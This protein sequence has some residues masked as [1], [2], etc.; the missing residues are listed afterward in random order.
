MGPE[1]NSEL[2]TY[3]FAATNDQNRKIILESL[4]GTSSSSQVAQ[5]DFDPLNREDVLRLFR[6]NNE[7]KYEL[8]FPAAKDPN[9]RG[10]TEEEAV[11]VLT[12]ENGFLYYKAGD[13]SSPNV[14]WQG[15]WVPFKGDAP[16]FADGNDP[17]FRMSKEALQ[18]QKK[19]KALDVQLLWEKRAEKAAGFVYGSKLDHTG[20]DAYKTFDEIWVSN[21]KSHGGVDY[22]IVDRSDLSEDDV[23]AMTM[24]NLAN[25]EYTE[26]VIGGYRD[27]VTDKN[28]IMV[29]QL[30][31][32]LDT[33]L[34]RHNTNRSPTFVDPLAKARQQTHLDLTEHTQRAEDPQGRY[35]R[36]GKAL[37]NGLPALMATMSIPFTLSAEVIS[38][39]SQAR[40]VQSLIERHPELLNVARAEAD[41]SGTRELFEKN[42]RNCRTLSRLY[43]YGKQA[44]EDELRLSKHQAGLLY[45]S[46]GKKI[47]LSKVE[48]EKLR[49]EADT[50]NA[51]QSMMKT[52]TEQVNNSILDLIQGEAMDQQMFVTTGKSK[53][54]KETIPQESRAVFKEIP[55]V[56][57]FLAYQNQE[58]AP[59]LKL[60][61]EHE[62]GMKAFEEVLR[63]TGLTKDSRENNA[64]LTKAL[65]GHGL[66]PPDNVSDPKF[67]Y[68]RAIREFAVRQADRKAYGLAF[69]SEEGRKR[70]LTQLY[71]KEDTATASG[72]R[73][74]DPTSREDLLRLYRRNEDGKYAPAFPE[75]A[76][77]KFKPLT[78]EQILDVFDPKKGYLYFSA[79]F[80]DPRSA[81]VFTEN[82]T[83]L[84]WSKSDWNTGKSK[85]AG[86]EFVG[87]INPRKNLTPKELDAELERKSLDKL[88][89]EQKRGVEVYRFLYGSR[90]DHVGS[91]TYRTYDEIWV[92]KIRERGGEEYP[93]P[94][95]RALPEDDVVALT[96]LNLADPEVTGR[97]FDGVMD[98]M[99][100]PRL[101][102]F[103]N[104][105]MILDTY[106]NR[107][108]SN[109]D[110]V[111]LDPIVKSRAATKSTL[112]EFYGAEENAPGRYDRM[113]D[114]LVRALPM[115]MSLTAFETNINGTVIAR[116]GSLQMVQ[117]L[118]ERHP[119]LL[120]TA[121]EKAKA[122]DGKEPGTL[123]KFE[124][125]LRQCR[126]QSKMY[127]FG[128]TLA[129]NKL[130]YARYQAG[131]LLDNEGKKVSLSPDGEKKLRLEAAKRGL[132]E[133]M[134]QDTNFQV[135]Q[136]GV[137]PVM[138][139]IA[140]E[141][142]AF[143]KTGRSTFLNDNIELR[144]F[145]P[146]RR[147]KFSELFGETGFYYLKSQEKE[148]PAMLTLL[149][150]EK[151]GMAVFDDILAK[152]KDPTD[153]REI[154]KALIDN[155]LIPADDMGDLS[156]DYGTAIEAYNVRNLGLK[157]EYQT[158]V[159][160]VRGTGTS[161]LDRAYQR[162]HDHGSFYGGLIVSDAI[163]EE[164]QSQPASEFLHFE[165]G[166]NP[167]EHYVTH[168]IPEMG[169]HR[170]APGE[171]GHG[172][173]YKLREYMNKATRF[174]FK[175]NFESNGDL[176]NRFT[177]MDSFLDTK[178]SDIAK[179]CRIPEK[180]TDNFLAFLKDHRSSIQGLVIGI[181]TQ[182][183]KVA[184]YEALNGHL[185]QITDKKEAET[186]RNFLQDNLA[187]YKAVKQKIADVILRPED[188]DTFLNFCSCEQTT[189]I[190]RNMV[191][192]VNRYRADGGLVP[193]DMTDV[194]VEFPKETD[195]KTVNAFSFHTM[196]AMEVT[197]GG[198]KCALTMESSAPPFGKLLY[199]PDKNPQALGLY[200]SVE[201]IRA[202][203][204]VPEN[205]SKQLASA[206]EKTL[207]DQLSGTGYKRTELGLDKK[208]YN[209]VNFSRD[210]VS[211]PG[212]T[213]EPQQKDLS[214]PVD[215]QI[216]QLQGFSNRIAASQ[217]QIR[218]F[219][220]KQFTDLQRKLDDCL[221]FMKQQRAS[222]PIYIGAS[223]KETAQRLSEL[224][225]Y[226]RS[227][228]AI[229]Q[230]DDGQ[231]K[232]LNAN[233]Q[234]RYD[235]ASDLKTYAEQ[236]EPKKGLVS[237]TP[238]NL[239]S[240]KDMLEKFCWQIVSAERSLKGKPALEQDKFDDLSIAI[241]AFQKLEAMNSKEKLSSE[242]RA[243]AANRVYIR[244]QRFIDAERIAAEKAGNGLSPNSSTRID[245]A[246][247][248]Q[249]FATEYG[250]LLSQE[251]D[252]AKER[253]VSNKLKNPVKAPVAM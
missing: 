245:L 187:D 83:R 183:Q 36:M 101:T 63:E 92:S 75:A 94:E 116:R 104:I 171:G 232:R 24:L 237:A 218:G 139:T 214:N 169:R 50:R 99:K 161:P 243:Q 205:Y 118:L 126:L 165:A 209:F 119:Q 32:N 130:R 45:D 25:P 51:L 136:E 79:G 241:L 238:K 160:G 221:T 120:E 227:Y 97:E 149:L 102:T 6:R 166:K 87:D 144:N 223:E 7:G 186:V 55:L 58:V 4:L 64:A 192:S 84:V 253:A 153:Y 172:V 96:L 44:M 188:S 37:A 86:P 43:G 151:G 197:L 106:E 198:K 248:L 159:D 70:V 122:L 167:G 72:S 249:G 154:H 27:M 21:V 181:N 226:V 14:F 199:Q 128:K 156:F 234:T 52:Y 3:G 168:K 134:L 252:K 158:F 76:G 13:N 39:C 174:A 212:K 230:D 98:P 18:E 215:R 201:E 29:Y 49:V 108:S 110:P 180:E 115:L 137:A 146:D 20:S 19:R 124:K 23:I 194:K 34:N 129:E 59:V 242:I 111:F 148:M 164:L 235:I 140:A 33:Y 143:A 78:E 8:A 195:P 26:N 109:T 56:G 135:M 175:L 89:K 9:F 81:Y 163:K 225:K 170:P 127:D 250:K 150:E 202:A 196:S 100:D 11:S 117:N 112:T 61:L 93:V 177:A 247:N 236:F 157:P 141:Q 233:G 48:A 91:D 240:G 213:V 105:E 216:E 229:K 113:A 74:F 219:S 182:L 22:P 2:E 107:K 217:K 16:V 103:K 173:S 5:R 193:I 12:P 15:G 189:G 46:E 77:D 184:Y 95:G 42:L 228:L 67:D 73:F 222:D 1:Q 132:V 54:L 152:A 203:Y 125:S 155:K 30:D 133:R 142:K 68:D 200:R 121:R 178:A 62:G 90:L 57:S 147:A 82:N 185:P 138:E 60:V 162:Q 208:P 114:T 31:M 190:M 220:S 85:D 17:F 10:L 224:G 38:R 176:R 239:K 123:E 179:Q 47:E 131:L 244:A 80:T 28:R 206:E 204:S 210:I 211:G 231:K 191:E 88:L 145:S 246:E 71:G 35:Q 53:Y 251:A 41:K 66:L 207:F 40:R 65:I 69:S